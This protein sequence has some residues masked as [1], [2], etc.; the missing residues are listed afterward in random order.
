MA[1]EEVQVFGFRSGPFSLRVE[2]AL[3]LKAVDYQH[4]EEDLLNNKSDL[5]L[6]YNPIYKK[7][8]VLVHNGNPISE[9]LVILEYI[10]HNWTH[11]PIFPAHPYDR[12]LARFW[13]KYIDDTVVPAVHKISRS[14]EE[15]REKAIEEAQKTLEPLE[16]ELEN[17]KFFGGE[18]IGLVDIVGLILAGWI[19]AIEEALGFELLITHKFPNLKKWT[20]EFVNHR[21]AKQ[22]MP[23]KDSLIAFL[24]NVA[25]NRKN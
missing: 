3:K 22:V 4:I 8:P 9:S 10:E 15:E 6:K 18:E 1:E 13:A 24:K 7:V 19:P 11:N 17:K 23:Q 12:A 16:N 20:E 5:L 21:V 2:L 25:L 14:T